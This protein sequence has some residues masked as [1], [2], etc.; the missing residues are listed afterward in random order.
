MK[1]LQQAW[2]RLRFLIVDP[3]GNALDPA[4][5]A[6]REGHEVKIFIPDKPKTEKIGQG[7]VTVVREFQ[8]WL[9]WADVVLV[10]DNRKYMRDID[11]HRTT[12]GNNNVVGPSTETSQWE[13]DRIT[14]QQILRRAGIATI[15]SKEFSDYA[16]AISYVKKHDRRFVSKPNDEDNKALSYCAKTPEDMLYMLERWQKL[17]KKMNFILQDFVEGSEMAVGGWFG[18]LGWNEGWHENWEFKKLMN[19]E[20]GVATGEQGTVLRIV[21]KSKLADKMLLPLTQELHKQNYV[22]YIDVNCIIDAKGQAWPL[23]FTTR[24]GWPT[25][26]IQLGLLQGDSVE[27]LKNLLTGMDTSIWTYDSVAI[28][29]VLSVPDYPYSHVTRRE[30]WGIPIY[31]IKQGLWKNLH[32][33][34]MMLAECPRRVNGTTIRAPTPATAGDYVLVMTGVAATVKDAAH[35]AYRRLE[36]LTVP[37]SPMWRTDIGRRLARQLPKIQQ[38]GYATGMLYTTAI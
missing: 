36:S 15:P 5:R 27:W 8:S 33:C 32:P 7:L 24:V 26:N 31:G 30:V 35:A 25:Y 34:E 12:L 9:R 18:P 16:A 14:G 17:G 6:Q 10:A 1:H 23:E 20:L 22:G 28:G 37:N 3:L 4:M 29:V 13:N 38:H 19:N 11:N 21:K 2:K